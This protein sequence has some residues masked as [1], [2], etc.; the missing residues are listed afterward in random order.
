MRTLYACL[1]T[2]ILHIA[3]AQSF[4]NLN[5]MPVPKSLTLENG[6][7]ILNSGFSVSVKTENA[8]SL[9]YLAANRMLKTLNRRTGLYFRQETI[10]GKNFSDT[11]GLVILVQ[12]KSEIKIGADES[13]QIRVSNKQMRLEAN[14]SIGAIRGMET[15]LQL[16]TLDES[17]YYFPTLTIQDAPRFAWRGLMIDVARHFIPA[18]VI[19]R[20]IEAMAA[21]KMNVLHL[22]LSDDQGFRVESKRF[23][24]LQEKGSKGQYYT[25]A[26]MRDL[27]DYARLRGII[28]VPEFDMPG[29]STSWF[30]GYPELATKRVFTNPDH[31]IR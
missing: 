5:L 2:C 16:L 29:H 6:R 8:D 11:A 7:F 30:A 14:T 15:I 25:Q 27:I 12:K 3:H 1:L 10:R 23:P 26:E 18:E 17:G 4:N 28:I 21:V 13:Y 24:L 22:H 20:N 9:V 19:K 31:H